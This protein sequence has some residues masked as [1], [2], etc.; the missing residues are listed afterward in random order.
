MTG[1]QFYGEKTAGWKVHAADEGL[2]PTA[3]TGNLQTAEVW[4]GDKR[5]GPN[6]SPA[7]VLRIWKNRDSRPVQGIRLGFNLEP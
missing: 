5:K 4:M 2:N 6:L 3:Y 1:L 7:E